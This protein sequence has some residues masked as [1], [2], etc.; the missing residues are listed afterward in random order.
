MMESVLVLATL[1]QKF[2]PRLVDGRLPPT[3]YQ[4]LAR[5]AGDVPMELVARA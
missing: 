4:V 3:E 1:A 2:A 5:P